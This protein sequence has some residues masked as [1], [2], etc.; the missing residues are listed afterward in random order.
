M[1][2]HEAEVSK[3]GIVRSPCVGICALDN[4]DVCIGCQRT[5]QEILLWGGMT[6]SE[7]QQVLSKVSQR[8]R[9]KYGW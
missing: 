7:K 9:V 6:D 4:S 3:N 1:T 5:G 2:S 8:E